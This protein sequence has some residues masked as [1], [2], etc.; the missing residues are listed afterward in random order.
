MQMHRD[1]VCEYPP[2][3]EPLGAS[4]PCTV[5]GMYKDKKLITVQGHPEF[6]EEIERQILNKRN[7]MGILTDEVFKEALGR[8]ANEQDGVIIAQ[9]FLK[10]VT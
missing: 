6:D 9:G 5:Q 1:V 2:G 10:L 7:E 3:V 8:V 4:A